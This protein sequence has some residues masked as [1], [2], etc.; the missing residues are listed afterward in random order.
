MTSERIID[1]NGRDIHTGDRVTSGQHDEYAGTVVRLIETDEGHHPQVVVGYDDGTT[2][3]WGTEPDG[4]NYR[5]YTCG[6][7]TVA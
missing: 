4:P 3:V 6:E 1:T 2:E 5:F 7:V